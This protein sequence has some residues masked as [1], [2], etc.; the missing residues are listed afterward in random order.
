MLPG[1]LVCYSKEMER[2]TAFKF[3]WNTLSKS[4]SWMILK[5]F[6]ANHLQMIQLNIKDE[7]EMGKSLHE[8][9]HKN[10]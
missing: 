3:M 7:M 1:L 9:Y 6:G 2:K 4:D 10:L 5:S 8:T